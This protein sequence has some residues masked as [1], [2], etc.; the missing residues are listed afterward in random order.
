MIKQQNHKHGSPYFFVII[1]ALIVLFL[2][3]C[4]AA[5][6]DLTIYANETYDQKVIMTI[7]VDQVEMIGGQQG[8]EEMLEAQVQD[9]RLQ[10]IKAS[11]SQ[12]NKTDQ[13]N[14]SYEIRSDR[15]DIKN[16]PDFS[17]KE[18]QYN[19][20]KAYE[21]EY[22]DFFSL[23]SDF[24][25]LS[26]TLHA[27]EILESNGTLLD[28][29]T[30]T[31]INPNQ[32]PRAIVVPQ[33]AFNLILLSVAIALLVATGLGIYWVL[34]TGKLKEWAT[35]GIN[36]GKW[37]IQAVKTA[38]EI[39]NLDS[40]KEKLIADLGKKAWK[41]RVSHPEY[42]EPFM[43]LEA[44]EKN[45]STL[46]QEVKSLEEKLK[47][48]KETRAKVAA[49]YAKQINKLQSERKDANSN[50]EKSRQNQNDLEKQITRIENEKSKNKEE[51]STLNEKL[52]QIQT[53]DAPDKD[54]KAAS[55]SR[56]ITALE[57]SLQTS[58]NKI[59]EIEAELTG[60][61]T[62]QKGFTEQVSR[63]SE[64][65]SEVQ[66]NQKAAL[67]PLD[68]EINELEEKNK[69]KKQEATAIRENMKPIIDSLGPKVDSSRPESEALE[70]VYKQIDK[71]YTEIAA[72]T[73]ENDLLNARL[74]LNDKSAVRNFYISIAVAIVVLT[75][76]IVLLF[77]AF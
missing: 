24:Q 10:G 8:F 3:G 23:F 36:A 71:T 19:N 14:F 34:K 38:R 56:A 63:I 59:P 67:E 20:R 72:K 40:E 46:E 73:E 26:L 30:V 48:V 31:W 64:Q 12:I 1:S 33:G 42:S 37:K 11:W 35:A 70:P 57:N 5:E 18:V 32:S 52:V 21:F 9:L 68:Q 74:S 62:V 15:I 69:N 29:R 43:Q 77:L 2:A 61:Q 45:A 51:I 7:P 54:E 39:K 50:L 41:E 44:F 17:W 76:I 47:Q 13:N 75:I 55:I 6:I 27:G 28:S 16:N 53:S 4:G 22:T 65:I 49:E 58:I 66:E 25:T 60:S